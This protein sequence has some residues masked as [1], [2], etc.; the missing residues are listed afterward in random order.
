MFS[1]DALVCQKPLGLLVTMQDILHAGTWDFFQAS[2]A[3][4]PADLKTW[5][6]NP[7]YPFNMCA[8]ASASLSSSASRHILFQKEI[9]VFEWRL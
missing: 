7:L 5:E 1:F 4:H 3:K 8:L 6:L 2:A 9:Y